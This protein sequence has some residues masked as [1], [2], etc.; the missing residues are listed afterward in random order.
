M[1]LFGFFGT[2]KNLKIEIKPHGNFETTS[3]QLKVQLTLASPV[4]TTIEK[5]TVKLRADAT[6]R[7]GN[8][9]SYQYLGEASLPRAITLAPSKSGSL[10]FAVPVD[11]GPIDDFDIPPENLAVASP[12]LKAAAAANRTSNYKYSVEVSYKAE[13]SPEQTINQPVRLI[14]PNEVRAG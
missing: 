12:E 4:Q 11:F 7:H 6:K 2:K 1:A 5:L 9:A 8:Q 13:N 14:Q 3:L 10:E